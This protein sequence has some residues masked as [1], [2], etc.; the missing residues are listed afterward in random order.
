MYNEP[1]AEKISQN[2]GMDFNSKSGSKPDAGDWARRIWVTLCLSVVLLG[3][4]VS[5]IKLFAQ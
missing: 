5:A 2:G 4:V 3:G 1:C